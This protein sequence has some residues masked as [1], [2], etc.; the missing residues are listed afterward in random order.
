MPKLRDDCW[1]CQNLHT[2]PNLVYHETSTSIAK[3]N[4]DQ[5]FHGYTFLALKWHEEELHKLTDKDRKTFLEDM[6]TVGTALA[7]ALKPDK[8]NYEI[9]GNAQP[10]LHAHI[11]PRYNTDPMWGRPIWAGNRKRK[12]LTQEEYADLVKKIREHLPIPAKSSQRR[13]LE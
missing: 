9:L 1:I 4:P 11:I 13:R 6:S 12:R 8:M 3:L 7:T 10:H 5:L 2:P